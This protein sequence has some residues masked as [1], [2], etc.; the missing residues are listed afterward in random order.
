MHICNSRVHTILH[1]L[2]HAWEA[3]AVNDSTR[4]RFMDH[5]GSAA[6]SDL[7]THRDERGIEQAA[8]MMATVL[9][10]RSGAVSNT[11]F[12]HDMCSYEILTGLEFPEWVPSDGLRRAPARR[13]TRVSG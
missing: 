4:Q 5:L 7:N 8:T 2:G 1:E 6:W 12:I 10:W 13:A 3:G 11:D 9:N